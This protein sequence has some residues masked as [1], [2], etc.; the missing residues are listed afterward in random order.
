MYDNE[1]A[2]CMGCVGGMGGADGMGHWA[3][4]VSLLAS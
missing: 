2:V 4:K 1:F 3:W